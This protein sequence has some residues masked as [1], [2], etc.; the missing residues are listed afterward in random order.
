VIGAVGHELFHGIVC[1]LQGIFFK[2]SFWWNE[3]TI[4]KRKIKIP[5]MVCTPVGTLNNEDMFYYLGGVGIGS[6][7]VI[8]SLLFYW[9]YMPVFIAMFLVGCAHFFYGLFEGL[10]IRKLE[11]NEFMRLHYWVYFWAI[12]ID[13]MIIANPIINYIW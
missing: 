8:I 1:T 11:F 3:L 13:M 5:S 2:I 10:Y 7:F 9:V 12:F 4:G 6:T